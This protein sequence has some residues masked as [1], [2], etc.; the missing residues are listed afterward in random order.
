MARATAWLT[1]V[2]WIAPTPELP[3]PTRQGWK[4]LK[5]DAAQGRVRIFTNSKSLQIC[6]ATPEPFR[7]PARGLRRLWAQDT[8]SGS[9]IF[10]RPAETRRA[11]G[12]NLPS[13]PSSFLGGTHAG[14]APRGAEPPGGR[15]REPGPAA[16]GAGGRGKRR[17]RGGA[18]A[19]VK[20]PGAGLGSADWARRPDSCLRV[21][22]GGPWGPGGPVVGGSRGSREGPAGP[23]GRSPPRLPRR[24]RGSW[25]P[26]LAHRA[27]P[28]HR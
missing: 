3:T 8:F 17:G 24:C 1:P 12:F 28:T 6:L 14:P 4:F 11:A 9:G 27:A 21:S 5:S 13:A 20:L 19:Q 25:R 7:M 15:A 23:W 16:G 22:V 10:E 26:G 2:D 18:G